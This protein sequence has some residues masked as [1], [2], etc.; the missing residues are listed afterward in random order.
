LNDRF[1]SES[2]LVAKYLLPKLK[3]ASVSLG[4]GL[5]VDFHVNEQVDGIADLTVGRGGKRLLVIEAK[6]KKKVGRIERDIEPRDPDVIGQAVG[7]AAKG[8]FSYYATC[9][10][11]RLVLF[12]LRPGVKA[13]ESEIGAFEYERHSDWGEQVLKT[14]LG[15]V[16]ARLKPLDDTLVDMLHEAV[17]DL[18]PELVESLKTALQDKNYKDRFIEWLESQG[19]EYSERA[20]RIIGEQ[21]AYLQINK[22]LFYQVIRAIYPEKLD[23]LKL[24]EEEDVAQTLKSFFE[25]ALSI[26][27]Q[28]IYESDILGEI[29]LTK[30]AGE[31]IRTLVDT[32]NEFDFSGMETDFVGRM[33]EKLISPVERKR[34]GQFYT[35]PTIVELIVKL[36][37][38]DPDAKVLDPGCGSGG[39]LVGAYHQLRRLNGIPQRVD[40]P[41]GER[42]HQQLLDQLYGV[43]I[44]QFPAHLSVINLAVQNPRARVRKINVLPKDFFD[45]KPGQAVL[46]GFAGLTVAGET[47]SL[48]FPPAFDVLAANP[49]YIR[50]ESVGTREKQK[51]KALIEGEYRSVSL[52]AAAKK[53]E[54]T[55]SI[56]KQSDIY[57]YFYMHGLAFLKNGGRLG[58][59][60]S[61]KWLEVQYGEPFQQFI[62]G[63]CKILYI[64]EFDKAVF[65]DAEVNSQVTILEKLQG[66]SNCD[67][68]KEN[69]VK[70][71]HINRPMEIGKLLER[72][73]SEQ[74]TEDEELR[75]STVLQG[76]LSPGK[77]SAYLRA[78]PVYYDL[79]RHPK[80]KRFEQVAEIIYGLKT[81]Y[82]PYFILDADKI[83]EWE[84]ERRYLKPCAP[85]GKALKGYVIEP[86]DIRQHF[87][88]V[89]ENKHKLRETNAL[90]YIEFGEKSEAAA[91]KRR[92][93]PVKLPEVET[94]K[95]RDLW[96]ELPELPVPS[97]LFPMW[98]RYQYRPLLNNAKA[99]ATDFYNYI[100][101]DDDKKEVLAALLHSTLTQ[102]LLELVGRQY[103]GM[104]H[105]KV[106]ELKQLP[107][108][109]PAEIS[110]TQTKR[111]KKLFLELNDAAVRRA[112]AREKLAQ[113]RGRSEQE[114]GLFEKEARENFDLSKREVAAAVSRIDEVVYDILGITRRQQSEIAKGL[115]QLRELRKLTTRGLNVKEKE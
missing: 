63:N 20:L 45:L 94:I 25:D 99:Y 109:D 32:L 86:K 92:K 9:N 51:I 87:L 74:K 10:A 6:F 107:I 73:Q 12:Q 11:K 88:I 69:P 62:L 3:D 35:P 49:P 114:R 14:I 90:K 100:V 40:G 75:I 115:K 50:Q 72:I 57:I 71:V 110:A 1:V 21:A 36:T 13:Y 83:K 77:W 54:R 53:E 17:A 56:D 79:R 43:D 26:D 23:P 47:T 66:A 18:H 84:I 82:D 111:L 44:N 68:R 42:F 64:I 93:E 27:Y 89:H 80:L 98:F 60:S 105:T 22:L 113:A 31:R 29:P 97:I 52:G 2:D 33:Y 96:Y 28:P 15:V 24:G 16:P 103:S 95:G 81:G 85:P 78:P 65:P 112:E 76:E 67:A 104:L 102:F 41:L 61:N 30:R 70:F 101:V 38:T 39:F 48:T 4:Q 108:L 59:I 46:S 58:F 91:S 55:I 8:G 106:Y 34:L 37:I 19:I 5:L 7:Y